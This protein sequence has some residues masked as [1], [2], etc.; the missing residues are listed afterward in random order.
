MIAFRSAGPCL[1]AMAALA[2]APAFAQEQSAASETGPLD[3]VVVTG[4][5][6]G[7]GLW[8]VTRPGD[9]GHVLWIVGDP[10]PFPK[11]WRWKSADIEATAAASQEILFDVG[12]SVTTDE[13]VGVLRGLTLLP[14]LLKARKNPDERTLADV[15]PPE[16]YARWK[17]QKKRYLGNERG[18]ESWRPLFAA[19]RLRRAAFDELDYLEGWPV[20][21]TLDKLARKRKIRRTAPVL[22]YTFK[23]SELRDR[24]RDFSRESLADVA[25][26]ASVLDLTEALARRDIEEARVR[27]WARGDVAGLA[28]LPALPNAAVPCAT[29]MLNSQVARD[30]VPADVRERLTEKWLEAADAALTTN[31]STLAVVPFDKLTR[32]GGYLARLRARGYQVED[33]P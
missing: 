27:A 26:F 15:L 14:S 31:A 17:E 21:R 20:R 25:C 10:L 22:T 9:D 8:R 33:P 4:E 29:A 1:Y 32:P 23:R 12:L 11:G 24:I 16:L 30:L 28:A 6:P 2:L 13:K 5:F 18:V 19:D 7:P 3:E